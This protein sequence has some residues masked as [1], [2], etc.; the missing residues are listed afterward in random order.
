MYQ[1]TLRKSDW[2]RCLGNQLMLLLLFYVNLLTHRSAIKADP[3]SQRM[4][5]ENWCAV[6]SHHLKHV[7]RGA[8]P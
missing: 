1:E 4:P 7:L 8:G 2:Y 3:P 6:P 5:R